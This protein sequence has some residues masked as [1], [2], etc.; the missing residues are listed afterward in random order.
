MSYRSAVGGLTSLLLLVFDSNGTAATHWGTIDYGAMTCSGEPESV[1]GE[2]YLAQ[3]DPEPPV[4]LVCSN[5][6]QSRPLPL[7]ELR[8]AV[9][10]NDSASELARDTFQEGS[11]RRVFLKEQPTWSNSAAWAPDGTSLIIADT[12]RKVLMQFSLDGRL[13]QTIVAIGGELNLVQGTGSGYLVEATDAGFVW[14]DA[15]FSALRTLDLKAEALGMATK[16][17]SVFGWTLNGDSLITFGDLERKEVPE[18]HEKARGNLLKVSSHSPPIAESIPLQIGP[19]TRRFFLIAYP[20]L[21]SAD[22]KSYV[23]LLEDT[24]KVIE[25]GDA[26]REL[27][28]FPSEYR[29]VPSLPTRP[30]SAAEIF[31]AVERATT[32]ISLVGWRNMLYVI[33]RKPQGGG[34]GTQWIAWPIQ[35]REDRL[36]NGKIL[37]TRAAHILIVPGS[38]NWAIIEKGSVSADGTQDIPSILIVKPEAM[39]SAVG[40][41]DGATHLVAP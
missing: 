12:R 25:L 19:K 36:L 21:A 32:A 7:D 22:G 30:E 4:Y 33:T 29:D 1:C 5:R 18:A 26:L 38:E 28:S 23:L 37:P 41:H 16:V 15:R 27:H 20:L 8:F 11:F 39:E 9:M 2:S 17:T 6:H 24:A 10:T 35:P 34:G 40:L 3:L 13:L 14:L 31:G